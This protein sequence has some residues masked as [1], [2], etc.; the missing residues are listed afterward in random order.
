MGSGMAPQEIWKS[1]QNLIKFNDNTK[2]AYLDCYWKAKL[3]ESLA[4]TLSRGVQV[5]KLAVADAQPKAVISEVTRL[6]NLE[7]LLP[8]YKHVTFIA[9]LHAV[10]K[11]QEKQHIPSNSTIF[12]RFSKEGNFSDVR[13]AAIQLLIDFIKHEKSA[14]M[15]ELEYLINI[16]KNDNES[17]IRRGSTEPKDKPVV[18]PFS[19]P[20]YKIQNSSSSVQKSSIQKA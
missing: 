5:Q 11:L 12:I 15:K 16:V 19:V 4:S 20:H 10:R 13:I 6:M 1:I 2:N 3:I 17:I 18:S 14:G 9:A 8:T 7:W